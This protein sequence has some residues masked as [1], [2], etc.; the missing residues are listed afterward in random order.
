MSVL[1]RR[2]LTRTNATNP[3]RRMKQT[4]AN[5]RI[6]VRILFCI[7]TDFV[8]PSSNNHGG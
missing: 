6:G 7:G 8:S 2:E 4:L 5:Q 1:H 3:K